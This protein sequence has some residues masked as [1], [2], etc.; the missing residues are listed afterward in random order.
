MLP[1]LFRKGTRSLR[2]ASPS[3][4]PLP[5]QKSRGL[6]GPHSFAITSTIQLSPSSLSTHRADLPPGV[7]VYPSEAIPG[8]L[9]ELSQRKLLEK[10]GKHFSSIKCSKSCKDIFQTTAEKLSPSSRGSFTVSS[11]GI[12]Q[13]GA[14]FLIARLFRLTK[15]RP[16]DPGACGQKSPG[17]HPSR[18]SLETTRP[19]SPL[20]TTRGAVVPRPS[21]FG[22]SFLQE[23]LTKTE[24]ISVFAP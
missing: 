9:A 2:R 19:F 18:V 17:L 10:M 24:D 16:R 13:F 4:H 15:S 23:E 1:T 6:T 8:D 20:S 22:G 12:G 14:L 21:A 7:V 3:P 5:L 11:S